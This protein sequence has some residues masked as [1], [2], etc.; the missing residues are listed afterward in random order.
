MTNQKKVPAITI[1]GLGPGSA[2][3][4]T[5]QARDVLAQAA[6]DR[7]PVYFRTLVHPTV[8]ELQAE[9][10]D[11]HITSFDDY[12]EESDDWEKLYQSIT[13][14]LCENAARESIIYAVPG[15]P[16]IG[17]YS[18]QLTLQQ[19]RE[20]NLSTRV[21]AGLSFLEPVC[22]ALELDPFSLGAQILDATALAA[23]DHTEI[24]GKLIPT[25]PLLVVQVYNR[26]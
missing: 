1:L 21:V 18:V 19:S 4:L 25:M 16:L 15:H 9:I 23:L 7:T 10:P 26:R 20:R 12:Y 24:A 8:A 11:L 22:A 6:Q 14:T 13:S 2:R 3:D 5:V 17:E